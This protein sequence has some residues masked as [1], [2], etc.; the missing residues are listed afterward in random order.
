MNKKEKICKCIESRKEQFIEVSDKIWEYAELGFQEFQS[1]EIICSVLEQEG[2]DVNK[3]LAGIKTAFSASYGNGKPIIAILGEYDALPNMSQRKAFSQRMTDKEGNGHGCGHNLLGA[4]SLAAAVAVK[5][6]IKET[7]LKGTI[8]YYGC[9][10]EED[11]AGKTFM[12]R[13]G[14]FNDV[15]IAL[16]WHPAD[17]NAVW[18]ALTLANLSV[19][20]R[21]HGK[22][23]HA[24]ATPHLGRSALDAVELTNIGANYLR[25]HIIPEARV[26]YAITN[27]GGSAPN[28]V[29]E[30]AEVYYFIRAPKI[31]QAQEIYDRLCNVAKGASLMTGTECEI[32]FGQGLSDFIPNKTVGE[33]LYRNLMEAGAP[34]FDQQDLELAEMFRKTLSPSELA[35]SSYQIEFFQGR[36]A[37]E[38]LESKVLSEMITPVVYS[39]KMMPGSTDVGDVS[40]VVPTAQILMACTSLGT[41]QHTWQF[42]SQAASSIGHKGM[43]AA[44]KAMGMAA[45]EILQNPEIAEAAKKEHLKAT[46]GR[47]NCPIPENIK[48]RIKAKE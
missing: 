43:L 1:S 11:G 3:G 44:G 30:F 10:G 34:D 15:D 35:N 24:A 48:P 8:R 6:Y 22:S 12:A 20:F 18:T 47:Y 19:Y 37:A 28:V 17:M 46:D 9:P 42:T 33:V 25:E 31:R 13:A 39:E 23:A 38:K 36:E 29:P 7:G 32:V 14:C 4:G 21:F 26:H 27:P 5:E 40:Y 41:S 2:F 16:C 45:V